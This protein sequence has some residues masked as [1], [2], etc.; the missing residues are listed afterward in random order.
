M[1]FWDNIESEVDNSHESCIRPIEKSCVNNIYDL[2]NKAGSLREYSQQCHLLLHDAKLLDDIYGVVNDVDMINQ[3]FETDSNL[4]NI[5]DTCRHGGLSS[6]DIATCNRDL[7]KISSDIH[8]IRLC[9][10]STLR[11]K[12]QESKI[13]NATLTRLNNAIILLGRLLSPPS[14]QECVLV[15][16]VRAMWQS[17]YDL[18]NHKLEDYPHE[19]TAIMQLQKAQGLLENTLVF[20]QF[21]NKTTVGLGGGFS[22]GK[23]SFINV[24]MRE[25]ILPS[26]INP[27]TAYPTY[28]CQAPYE[29]VAALNSFGQI[30]RLDRDALHSL[31]HQFFESFSLELRHVVKSLW[32]CNKLLPFEHIRFLDTPG[33]SK[34]ELGAEDRMTAFS[35]LAECEA[36]VWLLDCERGEVVESD[37]RFLEELEAKSL[38]LLVVINKADLKPRSDIDR[39]VSKAEQTLFDS[40][41]SNVE[42]I[43]FSC[44]ASDEFSNEMSRILTF[45]DRFNKPTNSINN[46][47]L[48]IDAVLSQYIDHHSHKTEQAK[49]IFDASGNVLAELQFRESSLINANYFKMLSDQARLQHGFSRDFV[50]KME[51]KK[52]EIAKLFEEIDQSLGINQVSD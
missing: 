11:N 7:V 22:A 32:F 37:K 8:D 35:T 39:I 33:Y 52:Q 9:L 16:K 5:L 50:K 24:L 18:L 21:A 46:I 40:G 47:H 42:V 51:M 38:P 12:K 26:S 4:E 48:V 10:D 44:H 30:A 49:H 31:S 41:Y 19:V 3:L 36:L 15:E 23:S 2:I 28:V 17:I 43:P 14:I 13:N 6:D 45:L 34:G 25:E 1:D 29:I 27:S 20:S